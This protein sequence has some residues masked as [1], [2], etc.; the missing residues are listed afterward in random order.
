MFEKGQVGPALDQML[1]IVEPSA[2]ILFNIGVLHLKMG[3]VADADEVNID[4]VLL[5][6]VVHWPNAS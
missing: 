1:R 2:K 4:S 6:T 3:N 5:L